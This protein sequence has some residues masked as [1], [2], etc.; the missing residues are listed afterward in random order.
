MYGGQA[1]IKTDLSLCGGGCT[2]TPIGDGFTRIG[3]GGVWN[4]SDGGIS[5]AGNDVF[6]NPSN[7]TSSPNS[8]VLLTEPVTALGKTANDV[9][10]GGPP[11]ANLDTYSLG[12]GVVPAGATTVSWWMDNALPNWGNFTKDFSG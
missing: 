9:V 4:T 5:G 12:P 8:S 6:V 10:N 2:N 11:Y 1:P 7:S 3:G